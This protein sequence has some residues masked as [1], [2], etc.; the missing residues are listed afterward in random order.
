MKTI[1]IKNVTIQIDDDGSGRSV[2]DQAQDAINQ[3]NGVLQREPYGLGAQ[4][5]GSELDDSDIEVNSSDED[6]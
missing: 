1:N 2:K 6:M 3:I 5:L 4:I